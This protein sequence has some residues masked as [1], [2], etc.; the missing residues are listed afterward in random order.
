MGTAGTAAAA[1]SDLA[2]VARPEGAPAPSTA[3]PEATGPS[4]RMGV[5][6]GHTSAA[7]RDSDRA[8]GEATSDLGRQLL[9]FNLIL[10]YS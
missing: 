4:T 7:A 1:T 3:H 8:M 2:A 10:E 9:A 6:A 5:V